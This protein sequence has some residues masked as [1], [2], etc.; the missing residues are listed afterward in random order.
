MDKTCLTAADKVNES[1]RLKCSAIKLWFIPL[2]M[3]IHMHQHTAEH[4]IRTVSVHAHL[5]LRMFTFVS[6]FSRRYGLPKSCVLT[7]PVSTSLRGLMRLRC[8]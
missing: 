3:F 6:F 4:H 7:A 8:S 5:L 1:M 2:S